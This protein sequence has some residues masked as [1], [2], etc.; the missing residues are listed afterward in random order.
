MNKTLAGVPDKCWTCQQS[1]PGLGPGQTCPTP[2]ALSQSEGQGQAPAVV[3]MEAGG[4]PAAPLLRHRLAHHR[5][6]VHGC[7]LLV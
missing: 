1:S 7:D 3:A 4:D 6:G 5:R 2:P